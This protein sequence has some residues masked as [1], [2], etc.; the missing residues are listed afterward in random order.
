MFRYCG[1]MPGQ[2]E[3]GTGGKVPARSKRRR[4]LSG[5]VLLFVVTASVGG[6]IESQATDTFDRLTTN[7]PQPVKVTVSES[8]SGG[9]DSIAIKAASSAGIP[10]VSFADG[11]IFARPL[12]EMTSVPP[13]VGIDKPSCESWRAWAKGEG[14][15]DAGS[16]FISLYLTATRP[17]PVVLDRA[18]VELVHRGDPIRGLLALCPIQYS[19]VFPRLLSIDLDAATP[20]VEYLEEP[21][22]LQPSR[23]KPFRFSLRQEE[24]EQF[25]IVAGT[26]SHYVTWRLR[27]SYLFNGERNTVTVADQNGAPFQTS[28]SAGSAQISYSASDGWSMAPPRPALP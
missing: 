25:I 24:V 1:G 14:G 11:Y 4:A 21:G 16:T 5:A 20:T 17:G 27:F 3:W 23:R 26:S 28:A 18:Q 19:R 9:P 22:Y 10:S 2:G 7:E 13:E 12:E 6:I 8:R 15:V